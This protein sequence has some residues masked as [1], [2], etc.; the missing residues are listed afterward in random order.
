MTDSI[1]SRQ[2]P[3]RLLVLAMVIIVLVLFGLALWSER[4]DAERL[5]P[6]DIQGT[7]EGFQGPL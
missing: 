4:E 6:A 7:E 2:R 1:P 5:S 3:W